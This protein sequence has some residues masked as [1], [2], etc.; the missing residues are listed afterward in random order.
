MTL[1]VHL[2]A[3]GGVSGDMFLA[4]MLDAFPELETP[5]TDDL[6]AAGINQHVLFSVSRVRVNGLMAK[7]V[8]F[9]VS[10]DAPPTHHWR[11]IRR[12]L[13]ELE[14][15]DTVRDHAIGIFSLLAKAEAACHG[16]AE[17]DVHFHEVADW[18]SIADI[19][20]AASVI[21]HC[22]AASWSVGALPLGQGTVQT[23]HGRLPVPAPAAAWLL[24]GFT[25]RQDGVEGERVTPTGAAILR[26]LIQDEAAMQPP[27]RFIAS[28]SGAGTK[29]FEALPNILRVLAI[30]THREPD[31]GRDRICEINFDID[32]MTP[33]E[34]SLALDRIRAHEAVL[35]AGFQLGYGKKGRARFSVHVLARKDAEDMVAAL[36][37]AE[38][39]TIGLRAGRAER[40]IL[41]RQE[42]DADAR[43]L[44]S[45][46]RPGGATAKIESDDLADIPTLRARRRTAQRAE[47]SD[48]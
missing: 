13:A 42:T 4:A 38:T 14:L 46:Q 25:M 34:I 15:P 27:G 22:G 3:L 21:T 16:V 11:D 43:R 8:D 37:F 47:N 35:D 26:Y 30:E 40:Y 17:D 2:D 23:A 9:R 20:G 1:H 48:D 19:V 29:R 7:Q 18:D 28:G 6:Q 41:A 5:L 39:S 10:S 33:E 12:W 24:K 44:K 36:C 45:A 31:I 32:D